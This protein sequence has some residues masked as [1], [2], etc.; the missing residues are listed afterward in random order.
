MPCYQVQM[1]WVTP[2]AHA[3]SKLI[4]LCHVIVDFRW[5]GMGM[6]GARQARVLGPGVGIPQVADRVPDV[7]T[8]IE[9]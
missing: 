2:L 5:A 8:H 1:S 7:G 3:E 9:W 4:V 6:A